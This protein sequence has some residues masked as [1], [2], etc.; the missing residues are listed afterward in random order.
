MAISFELDSATEERLRDLATRTGMSLQFHLQE[1]ITHCLEDLEDLHMAEITM[2]Q[3]SS[4]QEPV[5]S[6]EQVRKNLG[7]AD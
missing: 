2:T 6:S 5:Y 3:V 7:L 1:L 4:G